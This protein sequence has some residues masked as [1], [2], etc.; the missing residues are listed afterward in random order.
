MKFNENFNIA[1]QSFK[2]LRN[3]LVEEISKIDGNSF[4]MTEW[5]HQGG[6]GG[7][8]SKIRGSVIEKGGVNISSVSGKF[9]NEM[10][11]KIPGTSNENPNYLATGISVVLHPLSPKI[12]SM[13]FNTRFLKTSNEWFGGG[14]DLTP[15]LEFEDNKTYHQGLKSLCDHYDSTYYD[16]FSKWCNEYFFLHYR[17]EPRGIGGIFF[18]NL[19]TKNWVEDFEFVKE[20]GVYFKNFVKKTL[21]KLKDLE[22]T[23]EEKEIQLKKRSRY[24]EFNL[25]HDRGTKFGLETGGNIDAILMSMPPLAKWE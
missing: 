5:N 11:G 16:K 21:L 13:H 14:M 23:E 24:V 19:N 12:P 20:V 1:E 17:K 22:W 3:E 4:E 6:G 10:I 2:N 18:D 9:K 15:A 25:L 7:I 8:I